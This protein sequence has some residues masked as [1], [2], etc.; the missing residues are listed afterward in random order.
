MYGGRSID[1]LHRKRPVVNS[2]LV[3]VRLQV[4]VTEYG[5]ALTDLHKLRSRMRHAALC[6]V[7]LGKLERGL[8]MQPR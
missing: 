5:P 2:R 4:L 1:P 7:G 6:S 3:P 8:G